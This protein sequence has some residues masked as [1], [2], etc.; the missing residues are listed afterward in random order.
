MAE[1]IWIHRQFL[2]FSTAGRRSKKKQ[3][4]ARSSIRGRWPPTSPAH[5]TTFVWLKR[6]VVVAWSRGLSFFLEP[7]PFLL[8]NEVNNENKIT[9]G[10]F[11]RFFRSA[12]RKEYIFEVAVEMCWEEIFCYFCTQKVL[13]AKPRRKGVVCTQ[14][15]PLNYDDEK[16]F[17]F[18]GL[19]SRTVLCMT[20]T[21]VCICRSLAAILAR[22]NISQS[23]A[24]QEK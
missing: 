15:A 8:V 16:R 1:A 6:H 22:F 14:K 24:M 19:S 20:C 11:F 7:S 2:L 9:T 18:L 21:K 10:V 3:E 17:L 23:S 4:P 12:F 13:L 5:C